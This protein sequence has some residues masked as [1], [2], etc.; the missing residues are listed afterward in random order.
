MCF[1]LTLIL[2]GGVGCLEEVKKNIIT[3]LFPSADL[4]SKGHSPEVYISSEGVLKLKGIARH[5]AQLVRTRQRV[6]NM[7]K[8]H[9]YRDGSN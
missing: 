6:Q 8:G 9:L 7:V 3:T 5:R 1:D 4:L 2:K